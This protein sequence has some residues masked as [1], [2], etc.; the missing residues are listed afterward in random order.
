LGIGQGDEVITA[1]NTFIATAAAII[2]TGATPV[3]VDVDP[4]TRNIDINQIESAFTTR[5][6]AIIPVHLYGCMVDMERVSAIAKKSNLIVIE[7]A[8][9][10]HGA[11]FK[12]GPAGSFGLAGAFSFY[13]GKNLGAYGEGGAVVTS[14]LKLAKT[15]WKLR[16]HGSGEKYDHDIIGYNARM[17]GIHGAILTAKLKYLDR[18]NQERNRVASRYREKLKMTPVILPTEY[19]DFYQVYHLFVIE[20]DRRNQLQS[21]LTENDISTLIHYPVPIH[22]QKGYLDAGYKPGHFPVTERLAERILSLPIYPELTNRQID[23]LSGKIKEFF[24]Q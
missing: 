21:F 2:H 22:K 11:Q 6:K 13:P 5:T 16:N 12:G 18:W 24:D 14:D 8:C 4:L 19:K 20:T 1:A 15:I 9:Q 10:A 23:Y 7:D 3:L 17:D